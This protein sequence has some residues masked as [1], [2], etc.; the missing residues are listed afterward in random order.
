MSRPSIPL[1]LKR[2]VLL[3]AGHRCAIPTC[4]HPTTEL[5]H[6]VPY[7]KVKEHKFENLI[8]LCPNCHTRFDKEEIDRLAMQQY[9]ANLAILSSR[10]G[11][12]EKRVLEWF[13]E[14]P[15]RD[16]IRCP[17]GGELFVKYLIND[18][19]LQHGEV[20][21]SRGFGLELPDWK[22]YIITPAGRDLINRWLNARDI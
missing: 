19:Y 22:D 1:P 14:H 13:A 7:A 9:K 18:G 15:D 3:E 4:Q 17:G 2:E 10:Y 5:A 11:D 6:I 8:A 16:R 20:G 12:I 21:P